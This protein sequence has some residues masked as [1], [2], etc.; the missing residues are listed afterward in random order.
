MID[1]YATLGISKS[2]SK[3]E[4]TKSYKS[5]SKKYHPDKNPGN[6]VAEDKFKD[7]SEA[8][9]TLT[10]KKKRRKYDSKMSF[11]FD[12]HRYGHAFGESNATDF[13]Q[14]VKKESPRGDDLKATVDLS[15]EEITTGCEKTLKLN[16]WNTCNYCD[17]TGAESNK[18]CSLC[19]GKGIV[20]KI[21]TIS[22]MA[23]RTISVDT[24]S[25]CFGNGLEID[26]PCM[27][28]QGRGRIKGSTSIKVTIPK[29][30]DDSNFI[31]IP[32]QGDAGRL[33]GRK[34]DLKIYVNQL[35]HDKFTRDHNDLHII[36]E[37]NI[38][39]L[40]LG[41]TMRIPTL[42]DEVEIKIP[43][44]T[45]P[46]TKFRIKEKGIYN[47]DLLVEVVLII[48]EEITDEQKKLFEKLRIIEKEFIFE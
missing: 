29:G 25:K 38:T 6:T 28:C 2:A 10:D 13:S 11:S 19:K 7:I 1:Y 44:G 30:I 35:P 21:R 5:L 33:G 41:D 8:Y 48:P 46:N 32:G 36:R 16:K 3:E 9:S 23:G 39:D 45:Q 40:I 17:G 15:L 43:P 14:P 37:V 4:I 42:F 34:G 12:F 26:K 24:C 27:K 47:G 20:R 18:T 31:V 22:L